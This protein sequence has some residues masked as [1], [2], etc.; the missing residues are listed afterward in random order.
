[1]SLNKF[2]TTE[3]KPY[4]NIGCNDVNCN[5]VTTSSISTV[6]N[7]ILYD[8]EFVN[9]SS[10]PTPP[11]IGECKVYTKND[12]KLYILDSDGIEVP[13]GDDAAAIDDKLNID[14][15]NS[16]IANLNM[17][18][19]AIVGATNINA[20]NV[21]NKCVFGTG[22]FAVPSGITIG[23]EAGNNSTGGGNIS[24]GRLSGARCKNRSINI[25]YN[26]GN[27][28]TY[29]DEFSINMGDECA[30]S[31]RAQNGVC[32]GARSYNRGVNG[33]I[34]GADSSNSNNTY[35]NSVCIGANGNITAAD[36][37]LIKAGANELR[38]DNSGITFNGTSF[39]DL[40]SDGSIAMSAN[41]NLNNNRI[42][43]VGNP[44]DPLDAANNNQ[45]TLLQN[46]IDTNDTDITNLQNNKL[47]ANGSLPMSGT[48]FMND[49]YISD[50]LPPVN[51][52]DAANKTYVDDKVNLANTIVPDGGNLQIYG[53]LY[54]GMGNRPAVS[55]GWT[56]TSLGTLI[57]NSITEAS[58]L[59]SGVGSL[60]VP[61]GAIKEGSTSRFVCGGTIQSAGNGR[62]ITF[63]LYSGA[64]LIMQKQ[65][66]LANTL[67]VG[68]AFK[69]EVDLVCHG[70]D[71]GGIANM[72]TV[73]RFTFGEANNVSE[74]RTA[75]NG[76]T[77]NTLV[78]NTFDVRVQWGGVSP[79]LNNKIQSYL[80]YSTNLYQPL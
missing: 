45:I 53:G 69:I 54:V 12:N 66:T 76:G 37:M 29:S 61:I 35:A 33:V 47:N 40:K 4:L 55:G 31:G 13:V 16:M 57:E 77:I 70:V 2:T 7:R 38:G 23:T 18:N 21:T 8:A 65:Y 28:G 75:L 43:G 71:G 51:G 5:N 34:L 14:G 80:G 60:T 25:G 19:N 72:Y 62:Q 36:Q 64:S 22:S 68:S 6:T 41:L 44:I 15:S 10:T 24:I 49:N 20:T 9:T 17:N 32:I 27:G 46:Q 30:R 11:D 3:I 78:A 26:C 73:G 79:E 50:V 67:G 48:L 1:M 63:F 74:V 56:Q 42:V 59:G 39:G 58:L 52:S